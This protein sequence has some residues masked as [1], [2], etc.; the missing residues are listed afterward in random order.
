MKE[1]KVVGISLSYRKK[2]RKTIGVP[3]GTSF[4]SFILLQV[5]KKVRSGERK[6]ERKNTSENNG[7]P[8]SAWRT[9]HGR[10]NYIHKLNL[11]PVHSQYDFLK[12]FINC[13][14]F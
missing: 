1:T 8:S 3:P 7:I 4:V 5:G 2:L 12:F 11:L 14:R 10:T 9:Q 13:E 6:K